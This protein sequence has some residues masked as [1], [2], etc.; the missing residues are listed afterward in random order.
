MEIEDE[1]MARIGAAKGWHKEAKVG[2]FQYRAYDNGSVLVNI[3]TGKAQLIYD[4][5]SVLHDLDDL[6]PRKDE[7]QTAD[8]LVLSGPRPQS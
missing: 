4:D 1:I 5:E 7:T 2:D 8:G 6:F 3:K